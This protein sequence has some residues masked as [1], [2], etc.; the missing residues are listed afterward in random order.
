MTS[1][2]YHILLTLMDGPKHGYAI[3][4]AVAELTDSRVRIGPGTLYGALQ[5]L[6]DEGMVEERLPA[7]PAKDDDERRR[8]Y[9]LTRQGRQALVVEARR[10]RSMLDV[11]LAKGLFQGES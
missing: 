7:R 5:R 6:L 4:Q 11:A 3:S 1:A 8:Y 10:L 2:T 9:R